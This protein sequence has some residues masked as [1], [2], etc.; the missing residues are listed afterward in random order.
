M[1]LGE[2]DDGRRLDRVLR[3]ALKDIPL[4]A[5]HKALRKGD[6]R[7][8]GKRRSPDYRCSKGESLECRI[9]HTEAAP[10]EKSAVR[11]PSLG[12]LDT[13]VYSGVFPPLDILL[14]HSKL[15][16]IAKPTGQLVH[17]AKDSLEAQVKDYLKDSLPASLSFLPG[18]LHRL[19]RNSSGVLCFSKSLEGA[20]AF[21]KALKAGKIGKLYVALVEGRLEGSF[22]WDDTLT[23]DSNTHRTMVSS[24]PGL[25]TDK[26]SKPASMDIETLAAEYSFSLVLIRLHTGRTHQIRAQ[27]SFHGY[28]LAGDIKYG[29]KNRHHRFFLHSLRLE[30]TTPLLEGLPT[31]VEAP[32]PKLFLEIIQKRFSL[33]AEE[34]Y[35]KIRQSNLPGG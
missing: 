9:V 28:P 7:V 12:A 31:A 16:F 3:K 13:P 23:R 10:G 24:D 35:S 32:L 34:V 25:T 5:I 11:S 18:P 22:R 33:G 19:D 2:D 17:G 6:I 21:S 26:T 29:A 4:S 15:L 8:D 14:E 20:T 30:F 27:A 1:K